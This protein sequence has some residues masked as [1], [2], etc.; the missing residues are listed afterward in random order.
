M[1][2][3]PVIEAEA[4]FI[5][6]ENMILKFAAAIFSETFPYFN[7]WNLKLSLSC[8]ILLA[9]C[10]SLTGLRKKSSKFE[11]EVNQTAS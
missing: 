3:S 9:Y 2:R 6:P 1:T 11:F 10:S 7:F 5:I 8:F 4:H